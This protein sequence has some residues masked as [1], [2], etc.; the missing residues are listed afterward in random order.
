MT[1]DGYITIAITAVV[2]LGVI[3]AAIIDVKSKHTNLLRDEV[4]SLH[5][6]ALITSTKQDLLLLSA[7]LNAFNNKKKSAKF[8]RESLSVLQIINAKLFTLSTKF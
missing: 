3:T 4:D 7:K 6:E 8:I 1:Q 2:I 5:S